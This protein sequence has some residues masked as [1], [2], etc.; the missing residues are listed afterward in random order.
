MFSKASGPDRKD[1]SYFEASLC[2]VDSRLQYR[3]GSQWVL[4][5]YSG[6]NREIFLKLFSKPV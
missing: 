5:Y 3:V 2:I 4:N 6:I 1:K